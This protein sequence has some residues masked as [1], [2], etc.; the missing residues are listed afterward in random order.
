MQNFREKYAYKVSLYVLVY[1]F[2]TQ[3]INGLINFSYM[4]KTNE[5]F[6]LLL[7]HTSFYSIVI[8]LV[9]RS[10]ALT[11]QK[12]WKDI[13]FL[14][15]AI[16]VVVFLKYF[17]LI[18]I[19]TSVDILNLLVVIWFSISLVFSV[20]YLFGLKRESLNYKTTTE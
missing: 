15:V 17:N 5:V 12:K 11:D 4:E 7:N 20:K 6:L 8:A 2:I 16:P 18:S 10:F 3:I 9:L 1:F 19:N 13:G 14:F